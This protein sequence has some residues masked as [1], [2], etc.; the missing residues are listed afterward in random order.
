MPH[1]LCRED[2][3][4]NRDSKA[5][6]DTL[7]GVCSANI[8]NYLFIIKEYQTPIWRCGH[9]KTKS[10]FLNTPPWTL[11]HMS[12]WVSSMSS[13]ALLSTFLSNW[14][15]CLYNLPCHGRDNSNKLKLLKSNSMRTTYSTENKGEFAPQLAQDSMVDCYNILLKMKISFLV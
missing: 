8:Y 10:K 1:T 3:L 12:I 7:G 14:A 5:H 15:S 6:N 11:E 4:Q 13:K 2:T 9:L